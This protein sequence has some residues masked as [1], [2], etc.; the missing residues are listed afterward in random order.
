MHIAGKIAFSRTMIV[1][2]MML[3]Q[4]GFYWRVLHGS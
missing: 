1:L 4:A 2:L 3:V